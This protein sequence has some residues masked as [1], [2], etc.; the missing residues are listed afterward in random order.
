MI[1]TGH[2]SATGTK[3]EPPARIRDY[4]IEF[5]LTGTITAD[6]RASLLVAQDPVL[7]DW[8]H[9]AAAFTVWKND[10]LSTPTDYGTWHENHD[11][12]NG[13]ANVEIGALCM[14]G[15]GVAV[16]GP[17]GDCPF[18][19]AHA[20]MMA[21]AMARVCHIKG[22]DAAGSYPQPDGFQN[23]P[24]FV[25]STHGERALQTPDGP[26]ANLRPSFGYF[27]YSGDPDCRWDLSELD[28]SRAANLATPDGAKAA[29]IAS[30]AWLRKQAH[31]ILADGVSDLWGLDGPIT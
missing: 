3:A 6:L 16:A 26:A 8:A 15:E 20:W 10:D 19:I 22:L 25:L 12:R 27:A 17:W 30:A 23:G 31:A 11:P 18:T 7:V 9:L 29:C 4:H 14:G 21:G 5:A 1:A 28:Y 13:Q 2:W 24:Q